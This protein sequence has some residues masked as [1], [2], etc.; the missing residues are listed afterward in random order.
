MSVLEEAYGGDV[1]IPDT[2]PPQ[3]GDNDETEYDLIKDVK[4]TKQKGEEDVPIDPKAKGS[5]YVGALL[6]ALEI[7]S[8][9]PPMPTNITLTTNAAPT[10][11]STLVPTLDLY[12]DLHSEI[13]SSKWIVIG[14]TLKKAWL[15]DPLETLRVIWNARSIHL[16][17]GEKEHFYKCIGWLCTE[18]GLK[19]KATV[20]ANLGWVVDRTIRKPKKEE[21]KGGAKEDEK[22]V[23]TPEEN[24]GEKK[25]EKDNDPVMSH[26]Y[27]KDLSNLVVL[28]ARQ[29][30][31]ISQAIHSVLNTPKAA[32]TKEKESA[33]EV[34]DEVPPEKKKELKKE[35]RHKTERARHD[36]FIQI[37]KKDPFYRLLHLTVARIF[38]LQ[39]IADKALLDSGDKDKQRKITFAAKW[40]PSLEGFHDRHSFLASTIAE[41]LF[42]P[43]HPLVADNYSDREGFLK[44]AR[45]HYR[46]LYLS[47]LRAHL[48]IVERDITANKYS[49]IDY[50]R[51]P[52]LAMNRYRKLF[53]KKDQLRFKSFLAR[54]ALGK[55]TVSGGVLAPASL[56]RAAVNLNTYSNGMDISEWEVE[57]QVNEGQWQS[58]LKSIQERGTLTSAIA[59]V[60]VS[61]SMLGPNFL[62]GTVPMDASIGLGLLLAELAEEPFKNLMITFSATPSIVRIEPPAGGSPWG[63]CQKVAHIQSMDWGYNTNFAAVFEDLLLPMAIK[64]QIPPEAMIKKIFVF[65]DMQFDFANSGGKWETTHDRLKRKYAE[66]GYEL[67]ELVYWN[68]AGSRNN[69]GKA[70]T[71]EKPGCMIMSGGG[72]GT[73]KAFLE[74]GGGGDLDEEEE[75][76]EEAVVTMEEDKD[77]EE[78]IVLEEEPEGGDKRKREDEVETGTKMMTKKR[79]INPLQAMRKMLAHE[80]YA[81]LRVVG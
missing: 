45:E 40:A 69:T 47:P 34:E 57:S 28:G 53:S 71:A 43:E 1:L 75:V 67:P 76:E 36:A 20:L 50:N 22:E 80:A 59:V 64:N 16:G 55:A 2:P 38:A 65:S 62:D 81:G 33:K 9:P 12:N 31:Y 74:M 23:E 5:L 30:F 37:F 48:R 8:H 19:G 39:L 27:W 32:N 3:K 46:R 70:V 49:N 21:K 73:M 15:Q 56:V 29:A 66:A 72:A 6:D 77:D 24:N 79:K 54:V 51:V 42:P 4:A 68:L 52:S 63:L 78:L 41:C 7:Q 35:T 10:N 17:K 60:D 44:L 26:G 25:E 58:L 13:E 14:H 18:A 11:I 61:G